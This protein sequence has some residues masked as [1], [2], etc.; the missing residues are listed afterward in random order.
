MAIE[1]WPASLPIPDISYNCQLRSGLIDIK[2]QINSQRTR[3]YPERISNFSMLCTQIQFEIL[4]TFYETT[5]HGGGKLFEAN[6][7]EDA[8][9][10]FHRLRFLIPGYIANLQDGMF[11][12]VKMK[13][14]IIANVPFDGSDPAYWPCVI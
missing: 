9:F 4:K 10:A 14:E 6:W 11:W 7:L 2:E 13:F 1:I 8:G 5:L 12:E 3:T